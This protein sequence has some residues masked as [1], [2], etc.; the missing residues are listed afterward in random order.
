[1]RQSFADTGRIVPVLVVRTGITQSQV[2]NG[3][4]L[5]DALQRFDA[6]LA[7]RRAAR[8]SPHLGRVFQRSS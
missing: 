7:E 6:W 1:M 3:V 2:D 5:A 8:L 4:A